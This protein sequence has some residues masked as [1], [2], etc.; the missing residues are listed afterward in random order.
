MTLLRW[1]LAAAG[2][3]LWAMAAWGNGEIVFGR[4][5]RDSEQ[6]P[7]FAYYVGG[8]FAALG[9]WALPLHGARVFR[10][11]IGAW[12]LMGILDLGT[13]GH[14]LLPLIAKREE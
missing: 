9:L 6:R 8:L 12:I 5:Y 2:I 13:L 4:R 11:C 10:A 1:I 3:A 7:S 14:L